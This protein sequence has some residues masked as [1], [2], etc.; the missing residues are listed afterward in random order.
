MTLHSAMLE[1]SA[2]ETRSRIGK[3]R[4]DRFKY[5]SASAKNRLLDHGEKLPK[6]LYE[7]TKKIA[8]Q[9][10]PAKWNPTL[11]FIDPAGEFSAFAGKMAG[12]NTYRS[13]YER[14]KL[15]K[16]VQKN[17]VVSVSYLK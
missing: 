11:V 8:N 6:R 17:E 7:K 3:N 16:S 13:P 2:A 10:F 12:N 4:F 9:K 14:K 15:R 1:N 5:R